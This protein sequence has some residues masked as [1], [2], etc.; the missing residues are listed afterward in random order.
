[1]IQKNTGKES[2]SAANAWVEMNP[3]NQESTILKRVLNTAPMDA[4]MAIPLIREGIGAL[5]KSF[6]TV[7]S[8]I[9]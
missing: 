4:G 1:M 2:P 9:E 5:V 3:A 7:I 6:V 8:D